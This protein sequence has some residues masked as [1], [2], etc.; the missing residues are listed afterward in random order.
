MAQ[1]STRH[2]NVSDVQL[3]VHSGVVKDSYVKH[4]TSFEEFNSVKFHLEYA[5]A[6]AGIIMAAKNTTSDG[7]ILK[8]QAKE[9]SDVKEITK[10]LEKSLRKVSF[11]VKDY[12]EYKPSII[13]E[14]RLSA[15]SQFTSNSDTFI[16]YTKDVLGVINKYKAELLEAG[17]K[18]DLIPI[19][20]TQLTEL[21][22]QRREQIEAIQSRP[23]LTKERID[24]MNKL[25]K[26]LVDMR[27]ASNIVF[28]ESPEIRALF[29]L[30]KAIT[31][32]S[33]DKEIIDS[34]ETVI[35]EDN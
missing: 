3:I 19:I 15:I 22:T 33:G 8:E 27:D 14:F 20:E 18:E 16:G 13:K 7:F 1:L 28:D 5:S 31:R 21:D 6:I 9:T 34:D 4:Q 29:A 2:F 26:H 35:S 24:T 11:N 30:P 32:A 25:W 23:V 12:F 17:L 10:K